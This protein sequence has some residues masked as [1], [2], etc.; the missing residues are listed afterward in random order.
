[1]LGEVG[2]PSLAELTEAAIPAAIKKPQAIIE[3]HND[4]ALGVTTEVSPLRIN[5]ALSVEQ[6]KS[7]IIEMIQN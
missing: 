3:G 5:R 6:F 2:Y 1:M 7:R 4:A